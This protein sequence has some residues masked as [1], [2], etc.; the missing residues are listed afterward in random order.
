MTTF[1]TLHI[2]TPCIQFVMNHFLDGNQPLVIDGKPRFG[3][4]ADA[5]KQLDRENFLYQNPFGEVNSDFD[6]WLG[7]K[8]FRYFGGMSDSLIFGCAIAHLRYLAVAFVYVYDVDS[9]QLWS[10]SWRSPLGLGFKLAD[11][12]R[13][14]ESTF[15]I[16]GIVNITMRYNDSPREKILLL[17]C[18]GLT[19]EARLDDGSAIARVWEDANEKDRLKIQGSPTFV[20]DGG[21]TM[22]YGNFSFGVLH[23]TCE[24]L[25]RG[26]FP[27]GSAC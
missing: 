26:L 1:Y 8:D 2:I 18:R 15:R 16:P 19:I 6:K 24:E 25:V 7:C 3:H 17:K 5:L 14:G 11:N 13:A 4:F 23:A 9:G 21:R 22:L 10:R 20:F 27:G 12:P